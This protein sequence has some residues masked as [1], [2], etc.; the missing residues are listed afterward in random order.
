MSASNGPLP[1][2]ASFPVQWPDPAMESLYWTWDQVHFPHPV[3]PLTA[4]LETPAFT[5]GASRGLQ[6]ISIPLNF[7]QLSA[8]GYVYLCMEFLEETTE[9]PP[10]WWPRVEAEFLRR[11]PTLTQTWEQ[12]YLP[13][14]QAANRRLLDFDSGGASPPEL[15]AFID[16][17]RRLRA[18]MWDLH[19]QVV[20]PV[21]GAAS[22]FAEVYEQL[23]GKPSGNEPYLLLQGFE[24]KTVESGK[25]LWR[26]SRR[27]LAAPAVAKLIAETPVAELPDALQ[28]TAGGRAFWEELQR[29]LD[30]YG[31]RSDAFELSDPAWAEDPAILLATLQ[32]FLDAP[33]DAD[34]ALKERLC[35]EERE[36]LTQETLARL[37][38]H[39]AKPIFQMLLGVAQ[40]YL[41]IQENHN[42]YID[43]MNTVLTRRPLLE[44]GRRLA[45][46][47]AVADR[48]DVFYLTYEELRP[49]IVEP[50]SRGWPALVAERRAER[51]RWATVVPPRELGTPL[52]ESVRDNPITS[53]FFGRRPEPSRD[54]KVI[55]GTGASAGTVTATARIVRTL[56]EAHKLQPGDVLVCEMTMPA[57]T[58][59]FAT[60]AAVVADSGGT[61]SHCAIVAREY[62][63]PCV[64]GTY[65]GTQVLK[66]GQRITVDGAQGIVRIES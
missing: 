17:T 11:L 60:V 10:P 14:V 15:L 20:I 13:E 61:L 32:D 16:E 25:A 44:L 8:N 48:D 21:T 63:I 50:K 29:Y 23:L 65:V 26:L 64:V 43:Q 41:P 3:T 22:R 56:A 18:R 42:F 53:A 19:M 39:E 45:A 49:A 5:E 52:P 9:F 7:R 55:T 57:W 34:P 2:P 35:R 24:N 40:Q 58:P 66:D 30:E 46:A 1:I 47:G 37:D 59:L 28:G 51:E 31:W 62:R 36:R 38:G 27:A 4:T 54:P 12:E 6:A 33:D